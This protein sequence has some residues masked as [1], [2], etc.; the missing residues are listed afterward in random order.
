MSV[1][2]LLFPDF[3]L[4][5]LGTL[6]KRYAR[7]DPAF[8]IGL[9][10]LV[11]FVLFPSLLFNSTASAK[12]DFSTTAGVIGGC[13]A[14]MATGIVLG[15]LARPLFRPDRAVFASGVQCAFRF[16]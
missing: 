9:E 8:W 1:A 11:Y 3:A 7:F 14:A 2:L 15:W 6:L 5:F 13:F 10:R 4:I 12:L 16:T